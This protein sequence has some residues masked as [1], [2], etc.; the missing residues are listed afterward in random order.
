M[1]ARMEARMEALSKQ[2]DAELRV[3]AEQQVELVQAKVTV[4]GLGQQINVL[5]R[6]FKDL[7]ECNVEKASKDRSNEAQLGERV[8]DV[9]QRVSQGEDR[10]VALQGQLEQPIK[11]LEKRLEQLQHDY[12]SLQAST[13][14]NNRASSPNLRNSQA[15]SATKADGTHHSKEMET[16]VKDLHEQVARELE[17]LAHYQQ[18]LEYA[19]PS[20]TGGE[21]KQAVKQLSEQVLTELR[22]LQDHQHELGKLRAVM[23]ELP[24]KAGTA[25][26]HDELH[27]QREEEAVHLE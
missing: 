17:S 16:K 13:E 1:E 15:S 6:Q 8:S 12:E 7:R 3:F 14:G 25:S 24:E 23:A 11:A 21:I 2:V 5:Q 26:E 4:D 18:E 22:E 20:L 10:V 9:L 19:R 27:C